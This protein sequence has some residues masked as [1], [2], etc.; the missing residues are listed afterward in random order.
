MRLMKGKGQTAMEY[1]LLIA[2]VVIV[3]S[4]VIYMIKTGLLPEVIS[5]LPS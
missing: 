1:L 4:I 3:V 2:G 5:Q